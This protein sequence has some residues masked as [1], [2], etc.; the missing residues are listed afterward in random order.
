[1]GMAT[2]R[3][4]LLLAA[5]CAAVGPA[6]AARAADVPVSGG[7][8]QL[9]KCGLTSYDLLTSDAMCN[10]GTAL[11]SGALTGFTASSFA[12]KANLITG[13]SDGLVS[14]TWTDQHGAGTLAF[15][16]V[17]TVDGLAGTQHVVATVTEGTGTYAGWTGTVTFDGTGN[18]LTTAT[19]TYTGTL[20]KPDKVKKKHK[21]HKHKKS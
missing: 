16:E 3:R 21:K 20:V 1:M 10:G 6:T 11:W 13:S 14:E 15:R 12:G 19:G 18:L 9:Q 7:W 8:Q 2:L 5:V 4:A 17:A